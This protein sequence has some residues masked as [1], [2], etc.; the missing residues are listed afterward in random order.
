MTRE[1]VEF[2]RINGATT[3]VFENLKGWRPKAPRYGLRKNSTLGYIAELLSLQNWSGVNTEADLR[4]Y[5][6]AAPVNMLTMAVVPWRAASTA[7]TVFA[8][9]RRVKF[10]I[11]IWMRHI[12]SP[13]NIFWDCASNLRL[14]RAK[15]PLQH[16]EHRSRYLC[17]GR[18][19]PPSIV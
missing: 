19:I 5:Q 13:L 9:S 8:A 10:T 12:T 11:V 1:L 16:R 7:T 3:I 18:L 4:P 6:H 14:Q 17:F 2:A 15:A